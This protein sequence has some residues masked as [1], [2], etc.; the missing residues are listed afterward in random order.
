[1]WKPGGQ[2]VYVF[3]VWS[4]RTADFGFDDCK[5]LNRF[6]DLNNSEFPDLDRLIVRLRSLSRFERLSTHSCKRSS[7]KA[8]G[9]K[10]YY[11]VFKSNRIIFIWTLDTT[12]LK[13]ISRLTRWAGIVMDIVLETMSQRI[14]VDRCSSVNSI[15]WHVSSSLPCL[16][17]TAL[18]LISCLRLF[19][20]IITASSSMICESTSVI[21]LVPD[22]K[23]HTPSC[24]I[25]SLLSIPS[26]K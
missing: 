3:L 21:V 8:L 26:N 22:N 14:F 11:F 20:R 19:N 7:G 23:K 2:A 24:L 10:F 9:E 18:P 6:L 16:P 15:S 17:Q 1:M 5:V 25:F 13:M 4:L 12:C